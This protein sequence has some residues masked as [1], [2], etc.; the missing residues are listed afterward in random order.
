MLASDC[1][2]VQPEDIPDQLPLVRGNPPNVLAYA[3]RMID[4]AIFN[5]GFSIVCDMICFP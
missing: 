3:R 4:Q 1:I 2:G 5:S